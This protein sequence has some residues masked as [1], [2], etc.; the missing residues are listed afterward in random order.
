MEKVKALSSPTSLLRE[1][2]YKC[3]YVETR[4]THTRTVFSSFLAMK[5]AASSFRRRPRVY[6]HTAYTYIPHT[7]VHTHVP[8]PTCERTLYTLQN[9]MLVHS[10]API[11][12]VIALENACDFFLS[13]S[14]SLSLS[15][16]Q[17]AWD[18]F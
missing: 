2:S 4:S 14:L 9:R 7:R 5:Y 11:H 17:G 16:L 8:R 3:V 12:R 1:S 10:G 18:F 13:L 6:T 15:R